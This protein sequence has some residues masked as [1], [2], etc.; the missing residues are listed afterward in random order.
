MQLHLGLERGSHEFCEAGHG[1][2]IRA[3]SD[4]QRQ[5]ASI[6]NKEQ[7]ILPNPELESVKAQAPIGDAANKG[8]TILCF[9]NVVGFLSQALGKGR[10]HFFT[11]AGRFEFPRLPP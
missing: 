10:G 5:Q 8:V 6:V 11:F 9:P 2:K 1:L 4:G 7:I 3:A